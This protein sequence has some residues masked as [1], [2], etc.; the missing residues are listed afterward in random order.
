MVGFGKEQWDASINDYPHFKAYGE[1]MAN[2]L[3]D[4]L[5]SRPKYPV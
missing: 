3:A 4:Y 2:L 1:R 5:A